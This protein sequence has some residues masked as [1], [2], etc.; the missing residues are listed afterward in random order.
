MVPE[1]RKSDGGKEKK[2][3]IPTTKFLKTGGGRRGGRTE[4]GGG[5]ES[6]SK[7]NQ[8]EKKEGT[9]RE[10]GR[11]IARLYA[12]LGPQNGKKQMIA[13]RRIDF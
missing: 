4:D 13:K 6:I 8:G 7:E 3:S 10:K 5:I 9:I 1:K 2:G 12:D 11:E